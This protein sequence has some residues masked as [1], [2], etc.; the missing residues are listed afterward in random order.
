MIQACAETVSSEGTRFVNGY[1]QAVL[2][3]A[4]DFVLKNS[5]FEVDAQMR[6]P[7]IPADAAE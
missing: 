1:G 2:G 5:G 7:M 4:H 6:E 3:A